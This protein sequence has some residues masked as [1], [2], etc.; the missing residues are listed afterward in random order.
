MKRQRPRDLLIEV[1]RMQQTPLAEVQRLV[2]SALAMIPA[3]DERDILDALLTPD[4]HRA[5]DM[6]AELWNLLAQ[7]VVGRGSARDG[8]MAELASDVHRIQE[9]ILAQAAARAFPDRYRLLGGWPVTTCE[10]SRPEGE[11]D[12]ASR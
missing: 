8:D 7:K 1:G 6:T 12:A 9:R 4:E 10:S 3:T 5:M 11:G 2:D